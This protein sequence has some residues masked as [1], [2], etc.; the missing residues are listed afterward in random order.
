MPAPERDG[1]AHYLEYRDGAVAEA[2]GPVVAEQSVCIFVNGRELATLLCTP[3]HL[4]D[5]AVGFAFSE[6]VIDGLDDVEVMT[7]SAGLT[8][9][10]LWLRDRDFTPP[11][12]R[13]ITSGCGG[14]V[15]FDDTAD[16]LAR[17]GPLEAGPSVAPSVLSG[18]MQQ[19]LRPGG[20]D[21]SGRGM[22]AAALADASG[23][24]LTARDV[25]RHNTIDR[26]AGRALRRGIPTAGRILLSSGRLSSEMVAK[27]ARMRVPVVVSR[28][29]PTGLAVELAQAW[30]LTVVGYAR[31]AG[32]RVYAAPGRVDFGAQE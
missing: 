21:G 31:G 18:L 14:G 5:L 4:E 9:V 3:E 13:V 28:T 24:V 32:F 23:P 16:L 30:N 6:R 29:A 2:S 17:H 26:L 11:T 20:R 7:V 19:L 15:T 1:E 22:H 8:C 25:G 27:A 10:D 12:R